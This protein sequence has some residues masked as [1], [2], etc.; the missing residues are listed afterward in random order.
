MTEE[1]EIMWKKLSELPAKPFYLVEP[2]VW[3]SKRFALKRY[4]NLTEDDMDELR[5]AVI[6]DGLS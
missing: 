3:F 2:Q 4:L 6:A 1:Q 5:A